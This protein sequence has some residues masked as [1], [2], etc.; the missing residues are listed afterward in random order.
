MIIAP[1]FFILIKL[2]RL[3]SI[4]QYTVIGKADQ[5]CKIIYGTTIAMAKS[6]LLTIEIPVSLL[7]V[8]T[9]VVTLSSGVWLPSIVQNHLFGDH[10][11]V[12]KSLFD[13]AISL[14]VSAGENIN[15][16]KDEWQVLKQIVGCHWSEKLTQAKS[17]EN[18]D[19][20]WATTFTREPLKDISPE[21]RWNFV[22]VTEICRQMYG[23]R[24][25][26]ARQPPKVVITGQSQTG[27]STLFS[28]L[29]RVIW[30]NFA[31]LLISILECHFN[32]K[33]LF[34]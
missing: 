30:K 18:R 21:H 1:F 8:P 5:T 9:V 31:I 17:S 34:N 24:Q 26:L 32:V 33:L 14:L 12:M 13:M 2:K 25:I 22:G 27:K 23:M 15:E 29:T 19:T 20:V 28:Y 10:Q 3:H 16:N 7:V 11:I 4:E 6:E